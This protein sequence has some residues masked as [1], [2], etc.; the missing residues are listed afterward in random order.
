MA[1]GVFNSGKRGILDG[2]ISLTDD[3]IKVVLVGDGYIPDADHDFADDLA[4]ELSGTGYVDGFGGSG[5]KLL[6]GKTFGTN[7]GSDFARFF[8]N[9]VVWVGIDA[10]DPK[11]AVFV[12]EGTDDADTKLLFWLDL[13]EETTNGGDFTMSPHATNGWM[14]AL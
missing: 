13:G 1:S 3:D 4:D 11:Y 2:T 14:R 7:L 9:D 12:V 8:S 6:T 5:R 10:G